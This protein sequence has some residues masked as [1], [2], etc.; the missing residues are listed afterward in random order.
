M[1]VR[2]SS[3]YQRL[4]VE[5]VC[6]WEYG[7][8]KVLVIMKVRPGD[9]S[10]ETVL[11]QRISRIKAV[12]RNCNLERWLFVDLSH[13]KHTSYAAHFHLWIDFALCWKAY[14]SRY[15]TRKININIDVVLYKDEACMLLQ[16][17]ESVLIS[18]TT[19]MRNRNIAP[20]LS[21]SL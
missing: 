19:S 18:P 8:S 5:A 21:R 4:A 6:W 16:S 9:R 7:K 10:F 20:P 13:A 17:A 2:I 14:Q 12:G 11:H 15:H 1:I 3:K